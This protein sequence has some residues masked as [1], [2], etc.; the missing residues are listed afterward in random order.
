VTRLPRITGFIRTPEGSYER[1]EE[2]VY[3]TV[4]DMEAVQ[5]ALLEAG[6]SHAYPAQIQDLSTPVDDPESEGRVFFVASKQ[7]G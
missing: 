7:N 4:F 6:F 1:F 3:N 2:T 5:S